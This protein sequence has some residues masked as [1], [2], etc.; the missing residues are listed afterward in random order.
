[1]EME[2]ICDYKRIKKNPFR[3]EF[4]IEIELLNESNF[5]IRVFVV[6]TIN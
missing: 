6:F 5:D 1:M 2:W 4:P 3:I